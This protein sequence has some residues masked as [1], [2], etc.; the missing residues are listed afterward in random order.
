MRGCYGSRCMVR[1]SNCMAVD[2]QPSGATQG[3]AGDALD[4]PF[5]SLCLP[6]ARLIL[7]RLELLGDIRH[8]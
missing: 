2:T 6:A 3:A 8:N 5:M 7:Q 1:F 4:L